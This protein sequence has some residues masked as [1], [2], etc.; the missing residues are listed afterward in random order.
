MPDVV[1][2]REFNSGHI[3]DDEDPLA[4]FENDASANFDRIVMN[5]VA[6]VFRLGVPPG[7]SPPRKNRH[8]SSG[9]FQD[10]IRHFHGL[11][12]PMP[13][14]DHGV[15]QGSKAGTVTWTAVSLL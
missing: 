6:A 8:S 3:Q 15:G 4:G 1:V 9:I 2:M 13:S 10:G 11:T 7:S 5:L 12:L 14:R